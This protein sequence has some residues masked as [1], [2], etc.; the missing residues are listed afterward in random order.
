[1]KAVEDRFPGT[2]VTL[3]VRGGVDI[4]LVLGVESFSLDKALEVSFGDG[5]YQFY[6]INP[7]GIA[8][9]SDRVSGRSHPGR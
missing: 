8:H 4:D 9:I 6:C 2:S 5:I 7:L 1:M 3:C